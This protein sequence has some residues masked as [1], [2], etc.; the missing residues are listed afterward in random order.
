MM[1]ERLERSFLRKSEFHELL[2]SLFKS[3]FIA[4]NKKKILPNTSKNVIFTS[5]KNNKIKRRSIDTQNRDYTL[6]VR[7][8]QK[9]KK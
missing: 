6:F 2:F 9:T 7:L 1:E 3:F 5:Q 8:K 4:K